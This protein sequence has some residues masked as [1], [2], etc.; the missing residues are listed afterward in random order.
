MGVEVL[1]GDLRDFDAVKKACESCSL[2]FHTAAKAGVW[3]S[4]E[5]YRGINVLGT[6]HVI[7]GCLAGNVPKL[8]FTS[9]PSVAY[10]PTVNIEN[11]NES[12]PYP[13]EYLAHYPHSKALAEQKV[14]AAASDLLSTVSLR[15]HLIWGPR[16]P[17][18]LPRIIDRAK[19]GR[20]MILGNGR[21][22]VDITYVDN[23]AAAHIKAAE[24]LA[25]DPAKINGKA[26]FISDDSPVNIWSWINGVLVDC[27][28]PEI[29]KS[30]SYKKAKNIGAVLEF[31]FNTFHLRGEPPMT[32]FVAGQLAHS[33]YFDISA[34]KN[35][36]GYEPVV[37]PETAMKN[38]LEWL[39]KEIV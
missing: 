2:V 13:S 28:M 8:V 10:P 29:K 36:F 15:P 3:G 37:N 18:L 4:W 9:S 34:A 38:T 6:E 24:T 35:D 17:H 20:L 12:L 1:K 39:R 26:Y 19:K 21:N 31:I 5:E 14:K 23:G 32:R 25:E 11:A 7:N 33:H 16:D 27:G 30:I 22:M